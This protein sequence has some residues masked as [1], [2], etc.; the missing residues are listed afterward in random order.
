MNYAGPKKNTERL[1]SEASFHMYNR[2]FSGWWIGAATRAKFSTIFFYSGAR[3][4][5]TNCAV[6]PFEQNARSALKLMN[7]KCASWRILYAP[8]PSANAPFFSFCLNRAKSRLI[9]EVPNPQLWPEFPTRL[10]LSCFCPSW[11]SFEAS[12]PRL[13]R[14]C[15]LLPS[16]SRRRLLAW[17][18]LQSSRAINCTQQPQEK[19]KKTKKY[20]FFENQR[21]F[22]KNNMGRYNLNA[23]LVTNLKEKYP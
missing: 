21:N 23:K 14:L 20:I 16:Q 18:L 5:M 13:L 9:M 17:V 11:S 15:H 4:Q 1:I 19:W 6:L 8:L 12:H 22:T 7:E 3:T 10:S 2:S